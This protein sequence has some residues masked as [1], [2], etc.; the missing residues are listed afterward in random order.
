[1][2]DR[3]AVSFLFNRSQIDL[4]TD[5]E[6]NRECL[7][8]RK[9]LNTKAN[10][11]SLFPKELENCLQSADAFNEWI[12]LNRR[13]ASSAQ[14]GNMI[15]ADVYSASAHLQHHRN[16]PG[17]GDRLLGGWRHRE[18]TLS[19]ANK[20][21]AAPVIMSTA[22]RE[23]GGSVGIAQT[24]G[25][26]SSS[27][28]TTGGGRAGGTTSAKGGAVGANTIAPQASSKYHPHLTRRRA[29]QELYD[30]AKAVFANT[31]A[32]FEDDNGGLQGSGTT[33]AP[34]ADLE[35]QP[36]RVY[37]MNLNP[38]TWAART[39]DFLIE[40]LANGKRVGGKYLP[41]VEHLKVAGRHPEQL[42]SCNVRV[43]EQTKNEMELVCSAQMFDKVDTLLTDSITEAGS[44]GN[45][46][47]GVGGAK[48]SGTGKGNAAKAK[49]ASRAGNQDAGASTRRPA[50]LIRLV[51]LRV[52]LMEPYGCNVEPP[53][54]VQV[55]MRPAFGGETV[56]IYTSGPVAL[57]HSKL[58]AARLLGHEGHGKVA[59]DI[60]IPRVETAPARPEADPFVSRAGTLRSRLLFENDTRAGAGSAATASGMLYEYGGE[61]KKKPCFRDLEQW[62]H[63]IQWH[64]I[65]DSSDYMM[66]YMFPIHLPT[67]RTE[68]SFVIAPEVVG[69]LRDD[70]DWSEGYARCV[71]ILLAAWG[72]DLLQSRT[73]WRAE[74]VG[75][76]DTS[77]LDRR[78]LRGFHPG[79]GGRHQYSP[80]SWKLRHLLLS[81]RTFKIGALY[82][83]VCEIGQDLL[84]NGV[85]LNLKDQGLE[86]SLQA[87]DGD[88]HVARIWL[89]TK[90]WQ[91]Y[92][93]KWIPTLEEL[94][95]VP[96]GR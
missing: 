52:T 8:C 79:G 62:F 64:K 14:S 60:F 28:S 44:Y 31:E 77:V 88:I 47:G 81:L 73:T 85:L 16:L 86:E 43:A 90:L 36:Q 82:E 48:D 96:L 40:V 7:G 32:Y 45:A 46:A 11:D 54:T 75:L 87:A 9:M 18:D 35:S 21:D 5:A 93:K 59:V 94:L 56:P 70:A 66:P 30:S 39:P 29:T 67:F 83:I 50:S 74:A 57:T 78:S 4:E 84:R 26:G 71:E 1:M 6:C 15:S 10:L 17:L 72:Y 55:S 92:S 12:R 80:D 41:N 61:L 27:S 22:D 68:E 76:L 37:L 95:F 34:G 51:F 42:H 25:A 63:L 91:D 33:N 58:M 38:N 65:R 24:G 19:L 2:K 23:F 49:Q 3:K 13:R 20:D 53:F 69:M 89:E